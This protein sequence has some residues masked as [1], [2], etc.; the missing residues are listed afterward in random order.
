[1]ETRE[2][3]KMRRRTYGIGLAVLGAMIGLWGLMTA[4]TGPVQGA[5]LP[6]EVAA[7]AATPLEVGQTSPDVAFAGEIVTFTIVVTNTSTEDTLSGVTLDDS[8]TTKMP[9]ADNWWEHGIL[10]KY[11]SYI[12]NPP[13]AVEDF[14]HTINT[15]NHRGEATWWLSDMDPGEVV[16]IELLAR[17]PITVQ[18]A[19][20]GHEPWGKEIGPSSVENSVVG[21]LAGYSD[22]QAPLASSMVV[23]PLLEIE[24]WG[25]G[26]DVPAPR[27]ECR[28][29]RLVTY[30]IHVKNLSTEER[31]DAWPASNLYVVEKLP[32][33]LSTSVLTVTSDVSSVN[34][35]DSG[36]I[37]WT[38]P[39]TYVLQP[40]AGAY[41]TFTARLP[42]DTA[43][44][45]GIDLENR[46]EFVTV[47]DDR[48]MAHPTS[49]ADLKI[50]S[51]F[52]KVVT[53]ASDPEG[54]TTAYPGQPVT[55]TLTFYN[56]RHNPSYVPRELNSSLTITDTL[57]KTFVF[58]GMLAGPDPNLNGGNYVV[59][60]DLSVPAN[61]LI[62]MT[63]QV[64]ATTPPTVTPSTCRGLKYPNGLDALSDELPKVYPGHDDNE[65]AILEIAPEILLSKEAEPETQMIGDPV[66]YTIRVEN[67]GPRDIAGP[68]VLTDTLP[69][70]KLTGRFFSFIKM[71]TP[72]TGLDP[73]PGADR[74]VVWN[75]PGVASGEYYTF[76]FQAEV[77]GI[78]GK[79]YQNEMSAYSGETIMCD[80]KGARVTADTP[81]R[82]NK[83]A[84]TTSVVLGDLITYTARIRNVS[85]KDVYT[86][87]GYEDALN[88]DVLP[89]KNFY[90]KWT[91]RADGD[92][93]YEHGPIATPLDPGDT[94][95]H[96]FTVSAT[97]S[98]LH[99]DWCNAMGPEGEGAF[100]G[101][102]TVQFFVE[103][104][105][106]RTNMP[107]LAWVYVYPHVS[108]LQEFYPNP[109]AINEQVVLTLTMR[110]NRTEPIQPV[111]GITLAWTI[112]YGQKSD[113]RFTLLSTSVPTATPPGDAE[114][115]VVYWDDLTI[116]LRGE[117]I[118]TA[119]LQAIDEEDN[120][121]SEVQALSVD[122]P[123]ICIPAA[124]YEV[125]REGGGTQRVRYH[126]QGEVVKGIEIQKEP[127]VEEVAPYNEV[128][129]VLQ[130]ENQTGAVVHNVVIT[131][132]LPEKWSYVDVV[133]DTPEPDTFLPSW[134][135][136]EIGPEESV[137]LSFKARS[138]PQLG[139]QHNWVD[140]E[141]P[142]NW[143]LSEKY[144]DNVEVFVVSGIGFYKDVTPREVYT[145]SLVTYTLNLYNGAD[146]RLSN[147]VITDVLPS[148]FEYQGIV[149]GQPP[150]VV[151]DSD[152]Q[153]LVWR[154]SGNLNGGDTLQFIF[155]AKTGAD[156]YTAKYY[157]NA[158]IE[159]LNDSTGT[160]VDISDTGPTA[161]V[162]V[163]GKPNVNVSKSADPN[164]VIAGERL[165]YTLTFQNQT[166]DAYDL[167][168]TDTLPVSFTLATPYPSGVH[169]EWQDGHQLVIWDAL[170]IDPRAELQVPLPVQ[171]DRL[172]YE[173][174]Y[175]NTVQVQM[176]DVRLPE[177]DGLAR[178]W[179][180]ELPRLDAE[181]SHSDDSF[182]V[183][184][185]ETLD[186]TIYYTNSSPAPSDETYT[187]T[188]QA[189]ILTTTLE[190]AGS[191]NLI[192]DDWEE[193]GSGQYVHTIESPMTAGETGVMSFTV[194]V[195]NN[196]PDEELGIRSQVEIGY[197]VDA[198][199]ADATPKN[200]V[201]VDFDLL[202]GRD[203]I[204]V[205]KQADP[206]NVKA[207]RLV[208]YTIGLG[209]SD[210]IQ[211]PYTV[212]VVDRLPP[213]FVFANA[214]DPTNVSTRTYGSPPFEQEEVVWS[215]I[216]LE[217]G[218]TRTLQFQARVL[219]IAPTGPAFNRVY[220][221]DM[222]GR[223]LPDHANLAE[224][225]VEGLQKLDVQ[226]GKTDGI[227]TVVPGQWLT[228]TISY[229]NAEPEQ[230]E[231]K[232][233]Y[234]VESIIITDTFEP[235]NYVL[236][237]DELDPPDLTWERLEQGKYRKVI[238]GVLEPG[239][240]GSVAF[241]VRVH[242][243]IPAVDA[244]VNRVE[245]GFTTDEEAID[246]DLS[247]NNNFDDP[248]TDVLS[249]VVGIQIGKEVEPMAVRPG[250]FATYTVTLINNDAQGYYLWIT[251]TLPI[252]VTFVE[253]LYGLS[254]ITMT[255]AG[256]EKVVWS[257]Y[258][259]FE[260]YTA[261]LR[262]RARVD[263]W[264]ESG[265]LCNAVQVL[266][267]PRD[268]SEPIVQ[269][270]VE[271]LA[272][273]E[274]LPP[275]NVDVQVTKSD[276]MTWVG[277]GQILTYTIQYRAESDEPVF[278]SLTLVET[279][280]P[281]VAEVLSF[282]WTPIGDQKYRYRIEDPAAMAS[283]ELTFVVRLADD[284]PE[285]TI[286]LNRVEIDY[287]TT[288]RVRETNVENNSAVDET[289]ILGEG[290]K[291]LVT[292]DASPQWPQAGDDLIYTVTLY[293][294]S[295]D[296]SH[297][298]R[299]I[300]T[301]P[302]GITSEGQQQVTSNEF[303]MAPEESREWVFNATI[304]RYA[305]TGYYTNTVQIEQD[306]E[307]QS[308]VTP[309]GGRVYVSALPMMDV[310]VSK[311]DG[312]AWVAG[313]DTLNYTIRYTN[314]VES[315]APIDTIILTDTFMQPDVI[316]SSNWSGSGGVYKLEL[317]PASG[318]QPGQSGEL[319]FQVT[320]AD[321]I[322]DDIEVLENH[323][324][325]GYRLDDG[326]DS[327]E[328]ERDNNADSDVDGVRRG[329]LSMSK[330]VKPTKVEAGGAVTY[331][332]RLFN[333]SAAPINGVRITDTLPSDF[334]F[335]SAS[336]APAE[337]TQSGDRQ[338]II[339]DGIDLPVAGEYAVTFRVTTDP[340]LAAGEYCN[341]IQLPSDAQGQEMACVDVI[342]S[343]AP[344][345]DVQ[346]SKD[347]GV[348][349]V[350]PGQRLVYTIAYTNHTSSELPV[351]NVVLTETIAPSE[352]VNFDGGSAQ[353]LIGMSGR[354]LRV[355]DGQYVFRLSDNDGTLDVGA[356][357]WVTFAIQLAESIPSTHREII[358]RVDIGYTTELIVKDWNEENNRAVD[359][360]AL[361]GGTEVYLPVILKQY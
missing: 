108:L 76:A 289:I 248:D 349:D 130:V 28:V 186:Y 331:T 6:R 224:V 20:K 120:F 268:G 343:P 319:F 31:P 207:G 262:F 36:Y 159:A 39:S 92:D 236:G 194:S 75:L 279:V 242:P 55:Y 222:A 1:M 313:G 191:V 131:D 329:G 299:V 146:Y 241:P 15:E 229:T 57:Y 354:W 325:I 63:F 179:V 309:L 295:N 258:R 135:L 128:L 330:N 234:K 209:L 300:D 105:G 49:D 77:N 223:A 158:M 171:V 177:R 93:L 112:P 21:E 228:Y 62:S 226:I 137:D 255:E 167:I 352:Y 19:L 122:D 280:P 123:S 53:T 67:I 350:E 164:T 99:T 244:I 311:N 83:Y 219:K 95:S 66:T 74:I 54:E 40:G 35:V 173:G 218:V 178:V 132:V 24:H 8:W 266:R 199:T 247:N 316:Q 285:E 196:V 217:P 94:F 341:T 302:A 119:R 91:D 323:I 4:L 125:D 47:W 259:M 360:D 231:Y 152:P 117:R 249:G 172:A 237:P 104:Q 342:K 344:R 121:R 195:A 44:E 294:T 245:V 193:V 359:R 273:L 61:G 275:P 254:P 176:G 233:G 139:L 163:F 306:G 160:P 292:K 284:L 324:E 85:S 30:T 151:P 46:E 69:L 243:T 290:D 78:P 246:V 17:V 269:P 165:T 283:G 210:N 11:D 281:E 12:V 348:A 162:Y 305:Q 303:T 361:P 154:V 296:Q 197:V 328:I 298:V 337:V 89:F 170:P 150:E 45:G 338:L 79:K 133:G 114:P 187:S 144:T 113:K 16:E 239:E 322:P 180:T 346:V 2:S 64:T 88:Q 110:D 291:V 307:L 58:S 10:L 263:P 82:I 127:D 107:E 260:E 86:V 277:A 102:G 52:D 257:S 27:D 256:H 143:G 208:T 304:D 101:P 250:D 351:S 301:L 65:M 332:L 59:W 14:T 252:S 264:V 297:D 215:A 200:N 118:I 116:P 50:L 334:T 333:D 270:P 182:W 145:D 25:E 161:P 111:S 56:P 347:D 153:M 188:F 267:D 235:R 221:E 198:N 353:T 216:R 211:D 315:D 73:L 317:K 286:V 183:N 23:G 203:P 138:G 72:T 287:T 181:V 214:I 169:T 32:D 274:V 38:L 43:Y 288:E 155:T 81:F 204:S 272:C 166:F 213:D 282:D 339:W 37:T 98:G 261:Q 60:E 136:D 71:V 97:G 185:G 42:Q 206:T 340:F 3:K 149:S 345:I 271:G 22:A 33:E 265:T 314:A 51:P 321:S 106:T 26:E 68:L 174:S 310:Q 96:T 147:I 84:E 70:D 5:I 205:T 227:T 230:L 356:S 184:E 48:V 225:Q 327:L 18:P 278:S 168:V 124:V 192:A 13:S 7:P 220:V 34:Y 148:G 175:P 103:D 41:M 90:I 238:T 357:G 251:D 232:P 318:L 9:N 320:L 308:P 142:I 276:D 312:V 293:N 358:N 212:Q 29:G 87:T 80:F 115:G 134:T 336:I 157:N 335:A 126:Y 141:A 109:V 355:A 129:Y 326:A 190:P 140:A 100:Q 201:S 253:D 202:L 240:G 156:L 189:V